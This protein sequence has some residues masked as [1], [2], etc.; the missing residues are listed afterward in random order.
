M[1]VII[2]GGGG[3]LGRNAVEAALEAGHEVRALIRD[4][5][6]AT[7]PHNVE[8]V[9]GDARDLKAMTSAMSGVDA[10]LF[11]VNPPFSRWAEEF[12]ALLDVAIEAARRTDARLVFPAN[13]WIFGRG[14]SDHTVD[15]TTRPAPISVRGKLRTQMEARL[16][17]SGVRFCLVRLPE[18]YGPHVVTLTERVFRAALG[19]H[20]VLWPGPLDVQIELI[21]MPD[22]A[23]AMVEAGCAPGV[24]GSTFH[25]P[26]RV[27]TPRRFIA[28]VFRAAGAKVRL[29]S[30]PPWLLRAAAP[31]SALARGAAAIAHLWT[32]PILLDG[33]RYRARFGRVPQT[34]YD[35]GIQQTIEWHRQTSGLRL[36]R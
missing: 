28:G 6:Q 32:D 31:L 22:G 7:L 8:P 14:A 17:S 30:I 27:T 3:G 5:T 15:E 10:A 2:L 12:P 26:G 1:R 16:G 33:E 29:L 21:Y 20:R 23:Q 11:C 9:R 4:P 35:V 18:F 13:V 34:P 19:A 24:D 36:Q 25:V